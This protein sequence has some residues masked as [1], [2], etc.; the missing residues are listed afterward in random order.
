ML[1]I[2]EIQK[3]KN[4]EGGRSCSTSYSRGNQ[5]DGLLRVA[6]VGVVGWGARAAPESGP[7]IIETTKISLHFH[8]C[9]LDCDR[10]DA[11]AVPFYKNM[12][13]TN[14]T[15]FPNVFCEDSVF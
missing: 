3:M 2:S 14:L 12:V 6:M 13:Q 7:R 11:L 8:G 5:V 1:K 9:D 4:V 10:L 15:I